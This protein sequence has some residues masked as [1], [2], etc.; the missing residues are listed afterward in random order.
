M[1][2]SPTWMYSI[3]E[4][5]PPSFLVEGG[6]FLAKSLSDNG[7]RGEDTMFFWE[8]IPLHLDKQVKTSYRQ[9]VH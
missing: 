2:C 1:K 3:N 5:R 8:G 9:Q 7:V 6:D 4:N